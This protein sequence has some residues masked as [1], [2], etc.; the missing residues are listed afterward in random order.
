MTHETMIREDGT[1]FLPVHFVFQKVWPRDWILACNEQMV[2]LHA[3][4]ERPLVMQRSDDPRAV[5]CPLCQETEAF[6]DARADI[7][8]AVAS[9][10]F[11]S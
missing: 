6:L 7:E 2:Q 5:T 1:S 8:A 3:L 11:V 4:P 10:R 9:G